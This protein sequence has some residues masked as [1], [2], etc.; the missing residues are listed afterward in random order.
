MHLST[1]AMAPRPD[2]PEEHPIT[3]S[4]AECAY[5]EARIASIE[6]S[7]EPDAGL[8][9]V[10]LADVSMILVVQGTGYA[11]G[12]HPEA[13]GGAYCCRTQD[14]AERMCA[15]LQEW[16]IFEGSKDRA[17]VHTAISACAATLEG[18]RWAIATLGNPKAA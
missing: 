10:G 6:A 8:L 14:V 12:S 1:A 3:D 18:L 13:I 15:K 7:P 11:L 5:F 9:V 4:S 17:A 16:L 2:A